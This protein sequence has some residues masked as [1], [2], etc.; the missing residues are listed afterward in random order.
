V[1]VAEPGLTGPV[2][3]PNASAPVHSKTVS[4]GGVWLRGQSEKWRLSLFLFLVTLLSTTLFGSALQRN[5]E[6][7]RPFAL[8]GLWQGYVLFGHGSLAIWSGL[9]FSLPLLTIL[10]THEL[11][12]YL[13]CRRWKVD[14]SLPYFLPSPTLFGTLGAFIRIRSPIYT[15]K[16]L[17]DIGIMGPLAGFAALMPF[18]ITGVWMSRVSSVPPD[19][20][21]L[22]FGAPVA[23]RLLEWLRFGSIDPAHIVLHP[24][25]MAAWVGLLATAM[26]LLPIGQLDGGHIVYALFG[27]RGH[28]LVSLGAIAL[29]GLLGFYYWPWWFWALATFFFFR[30]HPLVYDRSPLSPRRVALAAAGL[31]AFI[32]SASIVP[33]R[34]P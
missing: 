24:F 32:L 8:D 12:H 11:G 17:F 14:A 13:E 10:L 16:S 4:S 6:A 22:V 28:R 3:A 2:E 20:G 23:L 30:R 1:H 26:N 5:F 25:A 31:L 29:L 18:L 19:Q 34:T 27:E 9:Q 33:I 7:G 21:S 15:R